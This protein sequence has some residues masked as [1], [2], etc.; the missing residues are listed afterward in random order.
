MNHASEDLLTAAA[1]ADRSVPRSADAMSAAAVID[2]DPVWEALSTVIDP[3]IRLD[4]V[5]LGLVYE[6]ELSE[7]AVC[8]TFTLTTPG[9]PMQDAITRGIVNAASAVPGVE[10]V[11]PHLVWEPRWHPGMIS[12]GAW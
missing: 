3:E 4:I 11:L 5:T 2:G 6:V 1:Q 10:H 12:E 9:C 8:V 7:D